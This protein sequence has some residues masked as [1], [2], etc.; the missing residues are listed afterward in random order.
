MASGALT[1][2]SK[3][4]DDLRIND[5]TGAV[6]K[7]ALVTSAYTPNTDSSTG[8][9]L[10]SDVSA[11]SLTTG[12]GYTAGGQALTAD[13]ATAIAGGFKYS[14]DNPS[15]TAAGG[16]IPAWR[17]AVFYVEGTLWGMVNPLIG[18]F[19]AD[20]T[21]ADIPATSATNTLTIACPAGGWFDAI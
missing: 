20:T 5:L 7:V 18:Y 17:Y 8:H 10:Y 15:W 19:L 11:N 1:L 12:F 2:Y 9:S 6:V 21:P 4:K 14:S 3:N 16:S 13:V